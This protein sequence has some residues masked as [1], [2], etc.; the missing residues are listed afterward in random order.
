[1]Q[2]QGNGESLVVDPV[3]W[4]P[5][6]QHHKQ[7]DERYASGLVEDDEEEGDPCGGG[8]TLKVDVLSCPYNINISRCTN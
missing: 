4:E 7:A 3:V 2:E 6:G 5:H 8:P 1:M